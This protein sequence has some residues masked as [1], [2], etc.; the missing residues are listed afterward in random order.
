MCHIVGY[1]VIKLV[2][3]LTYNGDNEMD[4]LKNE[5]GHVHIWGYVVH[6]RF[7]DTPHRKCLNGGCKVISLDLGNDDEDGDDES[8]TDEIGYRDCGLW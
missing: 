8:N 3:G 1:T 4:N 6:A 5:G 2:E 7:T